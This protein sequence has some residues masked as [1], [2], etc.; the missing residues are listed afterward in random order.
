MRAW[1]HAVRL[2]ARV[3]PCPTRT[4]L[5]PSAEFARHRHAACRAAV[6]A[7][8]HLDALCALAALAASPG[9]CRPAFADDG[10]APRLVVRRGRHPTLDLALQGGAVPNDVE[11]RWDGTR[12]AIVTGGPAA[13]LA[14]F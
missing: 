2:G 8:A 13:L 4:P 14:A 10:A 1:T 9:Y 5:A 6:A 3:Q 12:G 7:L 11:L